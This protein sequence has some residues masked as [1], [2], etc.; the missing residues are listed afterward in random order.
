MCHQ[1]AGAGSAYGPDLTSVVRSIPYLRESIANPSA[2]IR[3]EYSGVVVITREGVHVSGVLVR[4]S[5]S[6]VELRDLSLRLRRFEKS[7]VRSVHPAR[8]SLM[9]PYRLPARDLDDLAAYLLSRP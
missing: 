7:R 9:P 6:T 2:A 5:A 1:I 8:A 3:P 4:E